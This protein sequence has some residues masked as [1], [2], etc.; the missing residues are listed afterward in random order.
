MQTDPNWTNFLWNPQTRQVRSRTSTRLQQLLNFVDWASGFRRDKDIH[1]II[2]RWLVS[3]FTSSCG[4]RLRQGERVESE[5]GLF[6]RWRKWCTSVFLFNLDLPGLHTCSSRSYIDNAWSP[7]DVPFAPRYT[8]QSHHSPA[9]C[10][11]S[12]KR[13][14]GDYKEDQKLYTSY[15]KREIDTTAKRDV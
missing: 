5:V 8:I 15:V 12:W 4:R 2:H 1:K 3:T 10:I 11:W 6:N 9:I 7:Y 14:V 13:V